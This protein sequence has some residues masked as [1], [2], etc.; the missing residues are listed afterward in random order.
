MATTASPPEW[1]KTIRING[2]EIEALLD[3]GSTK[4]VHPQCMD[5]KD[6]LG[7]DILYH[8]ASNK[9]MY[10]SAASMQLEVEGSQGSQWGYPSI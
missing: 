5:E 9:K 10:F 3:T 8:T 4:M 6:Y 2:K 1:T 7:W